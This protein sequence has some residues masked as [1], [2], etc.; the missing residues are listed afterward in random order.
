MGLGICERL[1]LNV[2]VTVKCCDRGKW[3]WVSVNVFLLLNVKVVC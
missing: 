1:F 2:K 3:A